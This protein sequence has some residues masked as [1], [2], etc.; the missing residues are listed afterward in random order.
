M[1]F[2][3]DHNYGK[4]RNNINTPI[5]D[6]VRTYSESGTVRAH[7]PGHK[8]LAVDG[9]GNFPPSCVNRYDITEIAGADSLFEAEGI[10]SESEKNAS[11]LFGTYRTYY[12]AGGSTL[13]IQAMLAL[14][15]KNRPHG[16]RPVIAA[17][18]NCH[19]SFINACIM[20]DA[21]IKWIFPRY[22]EGTIVSGEITADDVER[23]LSQGEAEGRPVQCVY[24]TTPDYLGHITP[25][26]DISRVCHRHGAYLAA[27]NA[28]GAY[29]AFEGGGHYHPIRQGA[30]ICCDSAH[31]TLPVLTGGAYLHI[32]S[33]GIE[34]Y[35][36]EAKEYMAMF[37]STSPSYLILQSLDICNAYISEHIEE[38]IRRVSRAVSEAK[39]RLSA[40]WD[41][42]RSEP[43]RIT[44]YALTAGLTGYELAECL[45]DGG[46]E[47]E[48]ADIT[49]TVLMFSP[50]TSDEDVER[51]V[52]VMESIRQP[53]ILIHPPS[54][55]F[56]PPEVRM[57]VREAA[58]SPS[59]TIDID[60]AAGRICSRAYSCCPPGI[61]VV[62]GGEVFNESSIKIL[63]NYSIF[64]VNVVK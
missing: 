46:I 1:V 21:E 3:C 58:F 7:M 10:I 25:L 45:R 8:G 59:E 6:F 9:F 19:R 5:A 36:G 37:G 33:S 49:H 29:L 48:Y 51:V 42:E 4:V 60:H 17:G 16:Q 39:K 38:D 55:E 26:G 18:R 12:S 63:K 35:E 47:C 44:V 41:I 30:D 62:A 56:V 23:V 11:E 53:K 57:T 54:E 52:S 34:A 61:A 15:L 24:L 14:A 20:L 13:C 22:A 28:H 2:R 27:D 50:M 32:G 43:C 64:K 40:Y 31:K